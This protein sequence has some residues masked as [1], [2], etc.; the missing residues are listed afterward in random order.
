MK[1]SP[2]FKLILISAMYE[3]GGNV[4]HRL[5]DDHPQM[6]VYPFES[7][8]GTKYVNDYL[9]SLFPVKYRW[10]IFPNSSSI[11][12][13]YKMIIDEECKVRARTRYVS[14]FRTVDFDFSDDERL[15]A[16]A[17]LLKNKTITRPAI[18]E[19]FFR[20]TCLAWKNYKTTKKEKYYVGY[21]PIIGVDGEK[22]INDFQKNAYVIHVVRNPFSAYVDTKKRPVPLSLEHYIFGWITCQYYA[23]L[24]A[25]KF[26]D[27][28][29]IV[30]YE[31][32]IKSP[33]KAFQHIFKKL[34][35]ELTYS[36][37]YMSFNGKK[38]KEAYPWGSIRQPDEITNIKTAKEL[39]KNEIEEIYKRTKYYIELFNY[40]DFW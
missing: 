36:L 25:S 7:Q 11:E 18:I 16:F 28:F 1:N 39:N 34:K 13:I 17:K 20:S 4:V 24:F 15:I 26:A 19:A 35:I 22:I 38:L 30:R 29:F 14:K 31:D 21:S 40:S 3:N 5:L 37:E 32:V 33:K 23:N 2:R 27:N 8:L 10:P 6:L 12:E 9:S